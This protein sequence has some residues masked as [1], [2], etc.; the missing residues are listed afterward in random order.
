MKHVTSVTM[1]W[2]KGH[3]A[4]SFTLTHWLPVGRCDKHERTDCVMKSSLAE[5]S[6]ENGSALYVVLRNP[7]ARS[8]NVEVINFM[9]F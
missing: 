4:F 5:N 8:F 3:V 1:R 2:V 6:K 9:Q 7:S